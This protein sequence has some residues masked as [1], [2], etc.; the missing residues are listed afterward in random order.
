MGINYDYELGDFLENLEQGSVFRLKSAPPFESDRYH[1][2]IVLNY[3]PSSHRALLLVNGTTQ[4][5]KRRDALRWANID[6]DATTVYIK[7]GVYSFFSEDTMIDC[8]SVHELTLTSEDFQN[9][10]IIPVGDNI[11]E[12]DLTS[13][14]N[15]VLASPK[16][17]DYQKE[18]IHPRLAINMV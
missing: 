12:T 4:Y 9:G 1:V 11:S 6:V 10:R 13:I 7:G 15:A 5:L 14:I 17:P 18:I 2:F 16:V 3:N 8:N